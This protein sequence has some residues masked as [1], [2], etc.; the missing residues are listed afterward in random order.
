MMPLSWCFLFPQLS[1]SD[2]G[3]NEK[4]RRLWINMNDDN[5]KVEL[6]LKGSA[7]AISAILTGNVTRALEDKMDVQRELDR[8][9]EDRDTIQG[10]L[11][12]AEDAAHAADRRIIATQGESDR[13]LRLVRDGNDTIRAYERNDTIRA[14]ERTINDLHDKI[15]DLEN[16]AAVELTEEQYAQL[17]AARE[18]VFQNLMADVTFPDNKPKPQTL[19]ELFS[20]FVFPIFEAGRAP[21]GW[22]RQATSSMW[23]VL[24]TRRFA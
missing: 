15:R 20:F 5:D 7:T 24:T 12:K 16:K 23:H 19:A 18:N 11:W 21:A 3:L 1:P 17:A 10:K 8:T 9:R 4:H 14:H 6:T 13:L 22:S 2:N